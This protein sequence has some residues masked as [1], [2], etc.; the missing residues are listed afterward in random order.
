MF[1][2]AN[3][4]KTLWAFHFSVGDSLFLHRYFGISLLGDHRT[5]SGRLLGA[6]KMNP[7]PFIASRIM[8]GIRKLGSICQNLEHCP[9]QRG[10]TTPFSGTE[11]FF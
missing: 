4:L 7:L 9:I 11:R 6:A 8:S 2:N 5:E 10:N 3:D 1:L